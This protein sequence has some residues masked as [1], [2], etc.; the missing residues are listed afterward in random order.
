MNTAILV[1]FALVTVAVFVYFYR[2]SS[3]AKSTVTKSRSIMEI[4]T[5]K[6]PAGPTSKDELK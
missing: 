4:L 2:K 5:M 3:V 1:L 6:S